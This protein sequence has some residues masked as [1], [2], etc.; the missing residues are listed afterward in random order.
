[1]IS[2]ILKLIKNDSLA[3]SVC[4]LLLIIIPSAASAGTFSDNLSSG[5]NSNDWT[6]VQSSPNLYSLNTGQDGLTITKQGTNDSTTYQYA[7]VQLNLTNLGGDISGD[8]TMQVN[9]SNSVLGPGDDQVQ[10]EATFAN[11]NRFQD[12]RSSISTLPLF[13]YTNNLSNETSPATANYTN[14]FGTFE[15]SRTGSTVTGYINGLS[16]FSETETTAV[17][18]IYLSLLSAQG[19]TDL[20]SA[21]FS[22]F[23]ITSSAITATPVPGAVWLFGSALLG[24]LGFNRRK[25]V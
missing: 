25:S 17:T 19:V 13:V 24:F 20:P 22:N 11:T 16:I 23:T 2:F 8:F 15:I 1:M 5:L 18:E 12:T 3:T 7:Q 4:K 10:L 21:T 14:N 6:V 9:F